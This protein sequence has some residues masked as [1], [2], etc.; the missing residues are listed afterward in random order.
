[1]RLI[2]E[3]V[4]RLAESEVKIAKLKAEGFTEMGGEQPKENPQTVNLEGL[5]MPGLRA[6]AKEKGLEGCGGLTKAELLAALKDVM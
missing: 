3:N 4:E 5:D 6:L 2:K 1:M